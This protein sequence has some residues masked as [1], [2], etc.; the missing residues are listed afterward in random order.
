MTVDELEKRKEMFEM[1]ISSLEW[2]LK[3]QKTHEALDKCQNIMDYIAFKEDLTKPYE[4]AKHD[5]Q[6]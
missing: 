2:L 3:N 6:P 4:Q 1:A 5:L